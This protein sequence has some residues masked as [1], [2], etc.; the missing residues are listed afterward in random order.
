MC[1]FLFTF[2][3]KVQAMMCFSIRNNTKSNLQYSKLLFVIGVFLSPLS[4]M[5]ATH[6]VMVLDPRSFSPSNLT[7][8]VGD[9]VRWVNAAGGNRHDVTADDFSFQS[10]T[11]SGFTFEMTFNSIAEILYHCTVHSRPASSGGTLQNGRINVIAATISTDVSIESVNAVDGAY[12]AGEDFRVKAT[13]KNKG[14]ASSG[15]FNIN[16]YASTD[17]DI[18]TDD[19]L[20]GTME[21]NDLSAGESENIDE[22]IDLPAGLA[23]GDYFIGAIID[24]DDNDLSN[25]TNVDETPIFVF[26]EFTM[27]AGLNDAWFNPATS[28]Q[29]LFITVFPELGF[30]SLAWFTYDTELPPMDATANLGD[31]GHRW[32][33]ALGSIDG[34]G[35]EMEITI[36]SGG[37]FD[38]PP[39]D[40]LTRRDDGTLTLKFNNCNEGTASYNIPSINAQGEVPIERVA[41][42]NVALCNALLRQ[43]QLP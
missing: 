37:L 35:S 1:D 23:V 2:A 7:I 39:G 12:E 41:I 6:E 3:E 43:S 5:A 8:E 40:D 15:L 22:S 24:L 20:L 21:I 13:L 28:G 25:N 31:P 14:D 19:T 33:T 17:G 9:T 16:F 26:T 18:T 30:V 27:N 42:D 36:T 32:F 10:E 11:S 38:T 29:G 4:V 34:D